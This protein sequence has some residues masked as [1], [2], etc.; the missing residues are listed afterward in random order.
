MDSV[1]P[2]YRVEEFARRGDTIYENDIRPKLT[3]KHVGK[4]LAI[5]IDT[6]EYEM[7]PDELKAC[8]KLRARIPQAQIWT[9]WVGYKSVHTFGGRQERQELP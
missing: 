8:H 9:V 3:A 2:R 4:F 1:Q 7:A 5:D 6:G